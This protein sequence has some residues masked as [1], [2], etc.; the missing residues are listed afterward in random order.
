V[1]ERYS[2]HGLAYAMKGDLDRAIADYG[3]AIRLDPKRAGLLD[4]RGR[5]RVK[6]GDIERAIANFEAALRLDPQDV[7]AS[8]DLA[9]VRG[10]AA[11]APP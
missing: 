7:D 5:V 8:G 10:L 6:K 3:E 2:H 11:K 9:Q 1:P 4:D